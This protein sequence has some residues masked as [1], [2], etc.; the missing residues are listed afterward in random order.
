LPLP[1]SSPAQSV[2]KTSSPAAVMV[3][4]A[5]VDFLSPRAPYQCID[6]G[7]VIK[8]I[9]RV[10]DVSRKAEIPVIYTREAH[11]RNGIDYGMELISGAPFHCVEGTPGIE[12]VPALKP[13]PDEFVIDKRRY[14]AFLGT[15]LEIVLNLLG[16]PTLYLTGFTTNVCVHYTAIEAFQRDFQVHVIRECVSATSVEKHKTGLR[17]LE[18]ISESIPIHQEEFFSVF[19][20]PVQQE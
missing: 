17:M 5:Q 4:D 13:L 15:Y 3:I 1:I 14:N 9:A 20:D 11:S 6:S 19:G 16:H 18:Y 8:R 2:E 7:D 12:I 10:I